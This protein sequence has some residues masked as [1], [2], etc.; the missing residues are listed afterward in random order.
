[1]AQWAEHGL[2]KGGDPGKAGG[3][4]N[5]TITAVHERQ[6]ILDKLVRLAELVGSG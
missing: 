1:M 3:Y 5:P 2:C 4:A 6:E